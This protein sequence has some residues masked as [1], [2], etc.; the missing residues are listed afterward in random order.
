MV[1]KQQTIVLTT[2]NV[3]TPRGDSVVH[4]SDLVTVFSREGAT[5]S[6]IGEFT[7]EP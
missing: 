1:R 6:V 3:L 5:E 7:G 4:Q 2:A